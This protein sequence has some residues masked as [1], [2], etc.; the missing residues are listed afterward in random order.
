MAVACPTLTA[1]ARTHV[2]DRQDSAVEFILRRLQCEVHPSEAP[3]PAYDVC[4]PTTSAMQMPRRRDRAGSGGAGLFGTVMTAPRPETTPTT[5]G[6]PAATAIRARPPRVPLP[7]PHVAVHPLPA[8]AAVAPQRA[9]DGIV[10]GHVV[11]AARDRADS[12]ATDASARS[13]GS[14][15]QPQSSLSPGSSV[16]AVPGLLPLPPKH[17]VSF[18]LAACSGGNMTDEGL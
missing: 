8:A 15:G 17:P 9:A 12:G 7:V 5:A 14:D 13:S 16:G 1:Y 4:S 10:S 2:C 18:V 3:R 6:A 11:G